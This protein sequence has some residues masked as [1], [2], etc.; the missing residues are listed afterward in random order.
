MFTYHVIII[1]YFFNF[2]CRTDSQ[3]VQ[4]RLDIMLPMNKNLQNRTILNEKKIRVLIADDH[5]LLLRGLEVSL[6]L[7]SRIEVIGS[8]GKGGVALK[9]IKELQPEIVVVDLDMPDINGLEVASRA[10]SF[11]QAKF[12]LL[13]MHRKVDIL[14]NLSDYNLFGYVIKD[15]DSQT[16]M[17]A[18][19][20]VSEGMTYTP[21]FKELEST[22]EQDIDIPEKKRIDLLTPSEK[23]ILKYIS[24]Q[25]TT[26][27]IA[28]ELF[29]SPNTVG[30][31]RSNI[32]KKLELSG[33]NSLVKFSIKYKKYIEL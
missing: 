26:K 7:E 31:H 24:E 28:E 32:C 27:E 1:Y 17:E 15:E 2:G 16:I 8:A 9:M 33:T 21:F 5:P 23:V 13:T 6:K 30:N 20:S 29:V 19:T 12:I 4:N 3:L 18:I 10:K 14:N 22:R 11:S 25:K